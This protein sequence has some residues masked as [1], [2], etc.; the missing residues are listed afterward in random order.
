[1]LHTMNEQWSEMLEHLSATSDQMQAIWKD[2]NAIP[3]AENMYRSIEEPIQDKYNKLQ[4][5][6]T[7]WRTTPISTGPGL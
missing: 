3:E 2:F 7:G 5:E 1:M 4:E 6:W